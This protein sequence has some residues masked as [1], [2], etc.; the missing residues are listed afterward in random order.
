MPDKIHGM[1]Y[2]LWAAF[3]QSRD[4]LETMH[5]L[6]SHEFFMERVIS[7]Y[8]VESEWSFAVRMAGGYKPRMSV[9]AP[10]LSKVSYVRER[11][12][13]PAR[14]WCEPA[15]K[16]Q[17]YNHL[18]ENERVYAR[19]Q[20]WNDGSAVGDTAQDHATTRGKKRKGVD[21]HVHG[22]KHVAVRT[23]HKKLNT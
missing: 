7:S 14:M 8:P 18:A 12:A 13:D 19:N 4:S 20:D 11:V 21:A 1:S 15:S 17:K 9:L 5:Q 2:G 6:H 10:V 16:R 3:I 23:H 22:R